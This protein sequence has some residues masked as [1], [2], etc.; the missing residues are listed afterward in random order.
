MSISSPHISTNNN[1]WQ[2]TNDW[3]WGCLLNT[4]QTKN[5]TKINHNKK[6]IP[7]R[8]CSWSM[9][10][11]NQLPRHAPALPSLL[12]LSPASPCP[13]LISIA[14]PLPSLCITL[15]LLLSPFLPSPLHPAKRSG[16]CHE[17]PKWGHMTSKWLNQQ[18]PTNNFSVVVSG[19][20]PHI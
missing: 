10:T 15:S 5:K 19:S 17:L 6:N 11:K 13:S 8:L 9:S 14:L 12:S 2:I 4:R 1:S 18:L 20:Q 16:E 7:I 3:Q